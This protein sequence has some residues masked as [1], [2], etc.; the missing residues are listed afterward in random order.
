[1]QAELGDDAFD[2]TGA[3]GEAALAEFL[4]DDGG[5]GV[6][7]EEAL[8][9]DLA[10]RFIGTT[11][12]G[13]GSAFVAQEGDGTALE[14]SGAELEITLLAEAEFGGSRLGAKSFEFAFQEHEEFVG[15]FVILRDS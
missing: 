6:G 11:G 14:V 4:G 3:D 13:L 2:A 9:N 5:G 7:I 8:A 1:L 15:D 10:N 12:T